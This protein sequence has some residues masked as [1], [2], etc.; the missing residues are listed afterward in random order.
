MMLDTAKSKHQQAMDL[1]DSIREKQKSLDKTT[2]KLCTR[3][4]HQQECLKRRGKVKVKENSLVK[5]PNQNIGG[6][7]AIFVKSLDVCLVFHMRSFKIFGV[8]NIVYTDLLFK[9]VL[10]I[11]L[12]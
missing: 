1:L 12:F 3:L 7:Q 9:K 5:T 11:I 8:S 4:C 6:K 10:D 2:H